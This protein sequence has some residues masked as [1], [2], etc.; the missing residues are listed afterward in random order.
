MTSCDA[1]ELSSSQPRNLGESQEP[2]WDHLLILYIAL[3]C[4][5]FVRSGCSRWGED[6]RFGHQGIKQQKDF[7]IAVVP[8]LLDPKAQPQ[9]SSLPPVQAGWEGLLS[10]RYKPAV[11]EAEWG[12]DA[13]QPR[14]ESPAQRPS[15]HH[16]PELSARTRVRNFFCT[17]SPK[18]PNVGRNSAVI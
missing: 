16:H 7:S 6:E 18:Q 12:E 4:H 13:S 9:R 15:L 17:F 10:L 8:D 1:P 3:C 5:S 11:T 2:N 14:E